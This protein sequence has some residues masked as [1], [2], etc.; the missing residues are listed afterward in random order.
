MIQVQYG[1]K[2]WDARPTETVRTGCGQH[3]FV[4][5]VP[6]M[7]YEELNVDLHEG[8]QVISVGFRIGH[9]REPD[10]HPA[11]AVW[12]SKIADCPDPFIRAIA[13][14]GQL[15]P[16]F[17]AIGENGRFSFHDLEPGRYLMAPLSASGECKAG[18]QFATVDGWFV[19]FDAAAAAPAPPR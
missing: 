9:L 8:L 13:I 1:K 5:F 18:P 15:P 11:L 19:K 14:Y 2:K 3:R 7:H 17:S 10:P 16:K 12:P 6:F 4:I